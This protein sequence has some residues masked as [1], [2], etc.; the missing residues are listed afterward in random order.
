MGYL[1]IR[2]GVYLSMTTSRSATFTGLACGT[3]YALSVSAIDAALNY[4]LPLTTINAATSACSGADTTA[5]TAPGGFTAS[6][7][8]GP[9]VVL[10]WTAST[11]NVGVVGYRIYR[12]NVLIGSTAGTTYTDTAVT[13]GSSYTYYARA[14]DLATNT[15]L[16]SSQP[17]VTIP[18][19]TTDTSPPSTP[20]GLRAWLEPG[21]QV[22]MTWNPSGDNVKVTGYRIY[23]GGVQI[24]TSATASYTDTTVA[25]G[26]TYLYSVRAYDAAGN[27]SPSSSSVSVTT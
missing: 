22:A 8:T 9:K 6:V 15:S 5:P 18:G 26:T 3:T 16:P 14:Y 25:A 11:D 1:L 27:V 23:R 2:N 17:T 19:T 21:P 20:T 10:A 12:N 13:A 24:G 7:Q 4:S